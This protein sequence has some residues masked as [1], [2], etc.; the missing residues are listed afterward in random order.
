MECGRSFFP[1]VFGGFSVG[2]MILYFTIKIFELDSKVF[3]VSDYLQEV[4]YAIST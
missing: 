1:S 2:G 4:N 3:V